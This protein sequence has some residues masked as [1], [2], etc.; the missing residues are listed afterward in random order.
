MKDYIKIPKNCDF[1]NDYC[2]A[3]I[4]LF[5]GLIHSQISQTINNVESVVEYYI[6]CKATQVTC[7]KNLA[8][9]FSFMLY[10][11]TARDS[12]IKDLTFLCRIF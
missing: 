1:L 6:T 11:V 10:H 12:K 9:Y 7:S 2:E 5:D 8:W 3:Y 4:F